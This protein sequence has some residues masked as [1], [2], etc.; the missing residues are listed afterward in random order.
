MRKIEKL[1]I[2]RLHGEASKAELEELHRLLE[3]DTR[4]DELRRMEAAWRDLE[5]P[6]TQ[7]PDPGFTARAVAAARRDLAVYGPPLR[8][9]AAA[10]A[11]AAG[12][13]LGLLLDH[14][15]TPAEPAPAKPTDE[16]ALELFAPP[17][18]LA[19]SWGWAL[20]DAPAEPQSDRGAPEP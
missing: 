6:P 17:P 2:R 9:R 11:L 1:M 12:L 8:L 7:G 20:D 18:T 14:Y 5:A 3:Q 19:E 15:R 4:A 16:L 10:A 13:S